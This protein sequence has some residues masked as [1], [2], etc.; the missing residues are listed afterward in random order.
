[1]TGSVEFIRKAVRARLYLLNSKKGQRNTLQGFALVAK[2][3]KF[4]IL[5]PSDA[6]AQA[7]VIRNEQI[8]RQLIPGGGASAE[9]FNRNLN[10][11]IHDRDTGCSLPHAVA[12]GAEPDSFPAGN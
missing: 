8:M 12:Q 9:Y 10:L 7:W 11:I 3:E 4:L 5:R 6:Q 2:A 1:M